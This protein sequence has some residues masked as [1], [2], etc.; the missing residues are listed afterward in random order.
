MK[1]AHQ[2]VK[3]IYQTEKGNDQLALNKYLFLVDMGAG[4]IQIKN[5]IEE[6]YK[7]KVKDVN[8][9]VVSGKL[10]RVRYQLG[11]TSDWKKAIVTLQEGHKIEVA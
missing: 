9:Q 5:A 8:T 2:I 3:T 4:K 1:N 11:R 10:K 7:V 6:I